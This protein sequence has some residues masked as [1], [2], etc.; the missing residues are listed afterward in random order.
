MKKQVAFISL[1]ILM[2]IGLT[3]SLYE[4]QAR[5]QNEQLDS[6]ISPMNPLPVEPGVN[7][8]DVGRSLPPVD[9][10]PLPGFPS[11]SNPTANIDKQVAIDKALKIASKR[12]RATNSRVVKFSL[13]SYEEAAEQ[14][15][16]SVGTD[17]SLLNTPV[18]V[19]ELSGSFGRRSR[20]RFQ[21][22][23]STPTPTF[24]KAYVVLRAADGAL[25][26]AKTVR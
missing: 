24:T 25:L 19:I 12:F 16:G 26:I 18:Q 6:Q 3:I 20:S 4:R 13:T 11:P 7:P 14:L 15:I 1:F 21:E 9:T 8:E 5:A 10:S 17:R 23:V 2:A 22:E